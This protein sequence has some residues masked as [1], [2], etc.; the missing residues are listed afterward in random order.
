MTPVNPLDC[1]PLYTTE[2]LAIMNLQPDPRHPGRPLVPMGQDSNSRLP[3]RTWCEIHPDINSRPRVE[4]PVEGPALSTV[5]L[6]RDRQEHSTASRFRGE[7]DNYRDQ[8]PLSALID[9][10][11]VQSESQDKIITSDFGSMLNR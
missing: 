10:D 9:D 5:A 7:L 11:E 2:Q 1:P 4:R 6:E 8:A 3:S